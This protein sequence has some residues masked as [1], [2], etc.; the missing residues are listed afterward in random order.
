MCGVCGWWLA[1]FTGLTGPVRVWGGELTPHVWLQFGAPQ[2]GCG[3]VIWFIAKF[4]DKV[5]WYGADG[6]GASAPMSVCAGG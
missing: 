1:G 4:V 6:K 3:V 5:K 2:A